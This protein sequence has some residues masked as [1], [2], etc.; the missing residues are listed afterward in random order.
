LPVR[1]NIHIRIAGWGRRLLGLGAAL[2]KDVIS[3]VAELGTQIGCRGLLLHAE[4]EEAR[5]F[6]R[7]LV[8]GFEQSPTD[9]LHLVLLMKD[10]HHTL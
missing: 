8:P 6:Y 3:R 9:P 5:S 2:L 1:R 4:S 7:H 10:I